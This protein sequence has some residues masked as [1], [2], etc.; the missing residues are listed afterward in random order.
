MSFTE[1]TSGINRRHVG[2]EQLVTLAAT[3]HTF[4]G[5]HKRYKFIQDDTSGDSVMVCSSYRLLENL[6]LTC[7]VGQLLSE[8]V[9]AQQK[10]FHSGAE[11][12]LFLV[13]AWSRAALEC[14]HQGIPVRHILSAMTEGLEACLQVC[15]ARA[16]PV[17]DL[18]RLGVAQK[19]SAL[20]PHP[21][22]LPFNGHPFIESCPVSE[23]HPNVMPLAQST[24]QGKSKVL[25]KQTGTQGVMKATRSKIKLTHSRHFTSNETTESEGPPT[26]RPASQLNISENTD[27]DSLAF[28]LSHGCNKAMDLVLQASRIQSSMNGRSHRT[29]D[30]SKLVT[31]PLPGLP[32]DHACVISGYVVLMSAEQASIVSHLKKQRVRIVLLNGDLSDKYR[33]LGFNNPAGIRHVT[34]KQEV[35]GVSGEHKWVNNALATLLKYDVSVVLVNGV[36]S[37][38]LTDHCWRHDVLVIERVK[39][40]VL[41]DFARATGAVPVSYITQ[42]NERCVGAGVRLQAWREYRQSGRRTESSSSTAVS[43]TAEHTALVT[44]VITSSVHGKLQS[45]EDQFWG[46]AHRLHQALKDGRVLPGG[47]LVELHCIHELQKRID[48]TRNETKD[49]WQGKPYV[50]RVLQLMIDGLVDY[51][52]TLLCNGTQVSSKVDA[53]TQ[54]SKQLKDLKGDSSPHVNILGLNLNDGACS[55]SIC[56]T[57]SV[58]DNV[59][60]KIEA[61]RRALDLVFLVLQ[62]DSEIITGF[63]AKEDFQSHSFM[64]L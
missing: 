31:C 42:V 53:W 1:N 48:N 38:H 2:L 40:A 29:F 54:I 30:V 22:D 44:A 12:L 15:R 17:E 58:H 63:D 24:C 59:T 23:H 56:K 9:L 57:E 25:C 20:K 55:D 35:H 39:P 27:L 34:D 61:W 14:L 32:E 51:V 3:A 16:V 21:E 6:D 11:P 18:P 36:A 5:P 26:Q 45:L 50:G 52:S 13:G 49:E 41:S 7:S 4:L 47:G 64:V 10:A 8:T 28:A 37:E 62:T 43:V 33:H 19:W 46:C 60:V